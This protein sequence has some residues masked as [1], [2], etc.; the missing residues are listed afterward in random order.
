MGRKMNLNHENAIYSSKLWAKSCKKNGDIEFTK[1]KIN[2]FNIKN[3][4]CGYI[5]D[6][7]SEN[8]VISKDNLNNY[9]ISVSK[10]PEE[11]L[12]KDGHIIESDYY[13]ELLN[14]LNLEC[15]EDFNDITYGIVVR[16]SEVRR[17]PT[18]DKVY[19]N[20]KDYQLDRFMETAIYACE[21]CIIYSWSK[22]SK[23]CFVKCAYY[24]GWAKASDIAIGSKEEIMNYS[25][26]KDFIVVTGKRLYLEYNPICDDTNGM[27]YDMG[28]KI[29]INTK[30]NNELLIGGMYAEGHYVVSVPMRNEDGSLRFTNVLIPYNDEVSHGYMK[31]TRTNVITQCFKLQGERYG[32]G[33]EFNARDCSSL[34]MDV[35]KC[36]GIILPRNSGDQLNNCAGRTIIFNSEAERDIK[37]R[38]I[39]KARPG[40]LIYLRGH[41]GMLLGEYE[42]KHYIIH[43]TVGVHI[44]VANEDLKKYIPINGVAISSLEDIYTSTGIQYIDGIIGLKNVFQ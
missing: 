23:W 40:E 33:G 27:S 21:P 17:F 19:S 44:K 34:V 4:E 11:V 12:Y 18:E 5:F 39:S 37:V 30:W 6:I 36:F 41:V 35:F 24:M 3:I 42:G 22:D 16:R 25:K 29:P 9:I 15:L 28:V 1:D 32:W 7:F 13:E 31:C 20:P 26:A 2:K 14:N 10:V 8:D 38:M 43:D